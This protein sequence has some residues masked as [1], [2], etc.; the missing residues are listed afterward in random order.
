VVISFVIYAW[1][2]ALLSLKRGV[3]WVDFS[4]DSIACKQS[5]KIAAH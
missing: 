4:R 5:E 1:T 2:G 3:F